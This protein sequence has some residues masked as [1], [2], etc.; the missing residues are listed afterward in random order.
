M[1]KMIVGKDYDGNIRIQYSDLNYSFR[2]ATGQKTNYW[3]GD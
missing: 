1:A 2:K 3:M